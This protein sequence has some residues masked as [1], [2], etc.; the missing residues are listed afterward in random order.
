MR[1]L[2]PLRILFTSLACTAASPVA[3]ALA[4][5][6]CPAAPDSGTAVVEGQAFLKTQGDQVKYGAGN[7]VQL[8]PACAGAD[9]WLAKQIKWRK[10]V[11]LDS[12]LARVTRTTTADAEGRFR[13]EHVP[14]GDYY[15]VS[16]V[17]WRVPGRYMN[18]GGYIASPV[19]VTDGQT[20]SMVVIDPNAS[21]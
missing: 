11:P 19:H 5:T 7:T 1:A 18:E 9:R 16:S 3:H 13:F 6:S 12:T 20:A 14:A 15:A 10:D 17:W 4:Q 8:V 21:R 2:L